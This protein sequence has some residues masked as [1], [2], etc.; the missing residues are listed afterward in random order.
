MS[1]LAE[2]KTPRP[3]MS[4]LV[5]PRE[6]IRPRSQSEDRQPQEDSASWDLSDFGDSEGDLSRDF[7]DPLD[8]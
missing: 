7:G 4:S 5:R 3:A 2:Q 6:I 1:K 8:E